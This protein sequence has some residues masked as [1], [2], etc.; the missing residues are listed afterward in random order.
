MVNGQLVY[1]PFPPSAEFPLGSDRW[2][3]DMLSLLLCGARNT[4]VAC[5]FVTMVRLILGLTLGA[6]AGWRTGG[7]LDRL[8]MAMIQILAAL[9]MLL[10]GM[11]LILALDIRRGLPAF[12]IALALVG[13]GEI[14]Q[15]IRGEFVA[16]R[17]R[18]FVE[19]ARVIGLNGMDIA[20]RHLLPNV[21]PHLV[22]LSLL[23]IGSVLMLLGE[24]GFI[25]VF[26]GGGLRTELVDQ[27]IVIA[28]IPEWG[29]ILAGVRSSMRNSP[30][31]VLYPSMAFFGAVLGFNL[32]GEGLRRVIREAGV[33]TAA[34]V[35]KRMVLAIA[36]IGLCTWYIVNQ[37]APGT[38]YAALAS[39]FDGR[40]A[41]EHAHT[42]A[43]LQQ[44]APGFG[45]E[46]AHRA[47]A[48]IAQQ[49]A[50]YGAQPAAGGQ[51]YL[52]PVVRH[53]VQR[54]STPELAASRGD[55]WLNLTHGLDFGEQ[56]YHHG[57]SGMANGPLV[58]VGFTRENLSYRDY[59]GLDLRGE[60]VLVLGDN[61]PSG[62][63]N[64]ALIRGAQAILV[65][66]DG[67]AP[68]TDWTDV[69]WDT[70]EKPTFPILHVRPEAA[71]RLLAGGGQR[72][73]GLRDLI[74]V[75]RDGSAAQGWFAMPLEVHV[76]AR[77]ELGATREMTGY[78][79]LAI[80]P[81][82]DTALDRQALLLSSHYDL[83]EPD[84]DHLFLAA[85]DGPAGVAVMLE[86][87]RLWQAAG[88]KPRQAVLF[89]AWAGGYCAIS[90][91]LLHPHDRELGQDSATIQW[92]EAPQ[93]FRGDDTLANLDPQRLGQVG[94]IVNLALITAS[95]QYHY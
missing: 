61:M 78:N 44:D 27:S 82:N 13:W 41:L 83:P 72:L 1:P 6:L 93:P 69:Q 7:L 49:F 56:V 46:G 16:L 45:S 10:T 32:L 62:F 68:H 42:I 39:R 60:V 8:V 48:Y 64:E 80:L 11:I 55:G 43:A 74:A 51:E 2:G 76:R 86:T 79:V 20:I 19:G 9:P 40:Q 70:M 4:L 25:G 37:V 57:G 15:Y 28:D 21:L 53:V 58:L 47:A 22:V 92:A 85:S 30:W 35:S 59:R 38:S 24:L 71:D 50:A 33:N 52:Q 14:A 34:L 26:V 18:P 75:R 90:G 73:A 77:V 29:A 36:A 91:I 89:A 5:L 94:E 95:R 31:L 67:V 66:T 81:G 17:E 54:L 3:R 84:P 65:V 12:L 23:E 88:F 63:D 87:V